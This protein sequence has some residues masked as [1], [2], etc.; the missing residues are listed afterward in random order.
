MLTGLK[1]SLAV[2]TPISSQAMVTLWPLG[3]ASKISIGAVTDVSPDGR[4]PCGGR[5]RGASLRAVQDWF[6]VARAIGA[7]KSQA[8]RSG[9]RSGGG[10]DRGRQRG[11]AR[12]AWSCVAVARTGS[13]SAAADQDGATAAPPGLAAADRDGARS[14]RTT[15]RRRSPGQGGDHGG[16][17][18]GGSGPGWGRGPGGPPGPAWGRGGPPTAPGWDQRRHNGYWVG[19]RWYFGAPDRPAF[20]TPGYRPGFTPWRRGSFLPPNYQNY[21]V[22]EYARYP[23]A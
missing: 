14:W 11:R 4:L 22:G 15:S 8:S 16:P 23:P 13:R 12:G 7:V 17:P 18:R 5:P 3:V 1:S 6:S 10:A 9:M 21:V 2:G 20:Q 19:G